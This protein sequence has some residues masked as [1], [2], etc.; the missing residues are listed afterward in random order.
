MEA[1]QYFGQSKGKANILEKEGNLREGVGNSKEA[2]AKNL[3]IG[4][5]L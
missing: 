2:R 5:A 4:K 1:F 3:E